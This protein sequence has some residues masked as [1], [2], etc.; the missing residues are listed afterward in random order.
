[1]LGILLIDKPA[2]ITSHDV[3]GGVR[4]RLGTRR[5]G[6]AGTL[7]PLATGLLVV[8]VGPATRFLQ[9][10]PLEPKVYEA[11]ILFGEATNTYDAEGERTPFVEPPSD[12]SAALDG[13]LPDYRGLIQQI[14]PSFSAIKLN[15]KP[16]YKLAREGKMVEPEPRTVHI[17]EFTITKLEGH[18]ACARIECSGG[19]YIRSL[20][21]DVGQALGCGAHLTGLVRT[22]VG[23]FT[24]DQAVPL[25]SVSAD[26]LIP[27]RD[28]LPPMPLLDVSQ[29]QVEA[30]RE[31]RQIGQSEP[32]TSNLV[33]LIEPRGNVFSVARV[34]GNLLQP[35][36]VIPSEVFDG[37]L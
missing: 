1:L 11:E 13:V 32:G 28:A 34:V 19:T 7:D 15:G 36:C 31:G 29:A 26:C 27:L 18:R 6:H 16:L 17:G 30:V 4:K 12:L 20:A 21:H 14:P 5:V 23:R 22:K 8:A 10:L 2:G 33:G 35:E 25:D 9:Y 3:V 37:S 24:L